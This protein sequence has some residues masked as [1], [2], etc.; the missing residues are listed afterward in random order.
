VF[1]GVIRLAPKNRAGATTVP[2][3]QL[4]RRAMEVS[5]ESMILISTSTPRRLRELVDGL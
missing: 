5:P 4:I 3:S 2:A 1:H